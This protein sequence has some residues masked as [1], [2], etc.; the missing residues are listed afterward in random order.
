MGD[1]FKE[2]HR[3]KSHSPSVIVLDIK[4]VPVIVSKTN[5][6]FMLPLC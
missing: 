1:Y 6:D 3:G 2:I 4:I 5:M